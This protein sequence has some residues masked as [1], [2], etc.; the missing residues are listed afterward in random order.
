MKKITAL[1]SLL[2]VLVSLT[3][4]DIHPRYRNVEFGFDASLSAQ[5]NLL[6]VN[7]IMKETIDLDFTRIADDLGK[8]DFSFSLNSSADAFL[9]VK[10]GFLSFGIYVNLLDVTT[11]FSLSNAFFDL[12]GHG[13]KLDK[14]MDFYMG[15][16][17]EVYSD[18]YMPVGVDLGKLKF[19]VAPSVFI[20]LVYMPNP[21]AG[22]KYKADS[23]TGDL[24]LTAHANA[25]IYTVMDIEGTGD[26]T[27]PMLDP[28]TIIG[29][30]GSYFNFAG[31]D[32][33]G[34]AEYELSD[35]L[36][37]GGYIN[38]PIVPGR[39][40][41]MLRAEIDYA[42]PIPSVTSLLSASDS[43]E[44][45]SD[46]SDELN[47]NPEELPLTTNVT[48]GKKYLV[49][50]PF[51]LGAEASFRPFGNWLALRPSLG[52]AARNPFGKD[53][54]WGNNFYAEYAFNVDMRPLYVFCF[55]FTS[56]YKDQVFMQEAGVGFNFRVVE[57]TANIASSG[58]SFTK[59]FGI[60]GLMAKVNLKMGF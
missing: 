37:V 17:M 52:V 44:D 49:N 38:L 3:F 6:T 60:G 39:L 16:R 59:S 48:K 21:K 41:T 50:R 26:N 31:F 55:S 33:M 56:S 46:G 20:P 35:T 18:F 9:D 8:K 32:I 51:R 10:I 45:S 36:D 22:I 13:N 57:L 34:S 11:G 2:T 5:Q 19:T 25:T 4:A 12:L 1:L 28:S 54:K 14:E 42:L 15:A 58:T 30:F 47:G 53:F 24:T 27:I 23:T 29:D 43:D 40:D 7:E